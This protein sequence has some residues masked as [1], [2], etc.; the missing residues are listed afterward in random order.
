M[1]S[2]P[3][4]FS[5]LEL[6]V[7]SAVKILDA[8]NTGIIV[9]SISILTSPSAPSSTSVF[10]K[11]DTNALSFEREAV[12]PITIYE[13]STSAKVPLRFSKSVLMTT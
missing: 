8:D 10:P 5:K 3:A 11:P 7:V 12:F 2:T 1:A 6:T 4:T 13:A 9:P